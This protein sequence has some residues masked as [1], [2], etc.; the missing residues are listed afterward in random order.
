[1]AG[2]MIEAH[3]SMQAIE[4]EAQLK[5]GVIELPEPYRH[6]RK[7][8]SI[9]VIVLASEDHPRQQQDINRHAGKLT[10]TQDPPEY[11]DS[12]RGNPWHWMGYTASTLRQSRRS[13]YS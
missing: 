2:T 5:G 9:K 11:Q 12:I 8:R 4:F 10:L 13:R 3:Q 6:W 1:M 7:N